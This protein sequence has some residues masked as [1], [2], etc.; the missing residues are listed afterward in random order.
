MNFWGQYSLWEGGQGGAG[1][2]RILETGVN[3]GYCINVPSLFE[4][5]AGLI[6]GL[7]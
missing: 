7:M 6:A 1:S 5:I 2:N 4:A 3:Y